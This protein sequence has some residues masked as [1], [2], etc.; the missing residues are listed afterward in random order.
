MRRVSASYDR[1]VCPRFILPQRGRTRCRVVLFARKDKGRFMKRKI[2]SF[3]RKSVTLVK[4]GIPRLRLYGSGLGPITGAMYDTKRTLRFLPSVFPMRVRGLPSCRRVC[5]LLE[6]D[7]CNIHFCSGKLCSRI[8]RL[9]RRVSLL[10]RAGHLVAVL[11]VLKELARYQ[12]VGLLSS[13]TCGNSGE[14]LRIGRPIGGICACLFGRFGRGILLRRITSCMGRGPSTLYHCFGRQASGD[15]F[16]Y[17]TRVQVRRTYGL[18][19]C[20][21]L[22]ISRVTFRSNFGDMPCF[23]GR[24]RDVARGAPNRCER[25]VN[26][27]EALC[28]G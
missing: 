5:H 1:V 17:L 25:L 6:G 2:T 19:S 28:T 20:S 16:R 27:W 18:L 13:M 21:G 23:V 26:E 11:H 7:R 24:F 15:V 10:G 4:D 12:G 14:L 3:R 9:F 8:G 22:S